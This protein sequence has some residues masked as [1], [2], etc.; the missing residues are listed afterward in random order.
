SFRVSDIIDVITIGKKYSEL[1]R[2]SDFILRHLDDKLTCPSGIK[3]NFRNELEQLTHNI[4]N[5]TRSENLE[6]L[7]DSDSKLLI[8]NQICS[9]AD[10]EV[11]N[12]F[13]YI[14]AVIDSIVD[15]KN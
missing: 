4:R 8:F 12:K 2:Y 14:H 3:I 6:A 15:N 5:K 11:Y 13:A 10:S 1:S 7:V 9:V